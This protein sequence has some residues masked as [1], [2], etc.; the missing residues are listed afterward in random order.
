MSLYD[1]LSKISDQIQRQ[2]KKME[3]N[4]DATKLVSVQPFIRALG[5]D[6]HNLGEVFPEFKAD[7]KISGGERVDY[8]IL[9]EDKPII[10]IEAKAVNI[11]LNESNWKQLYNYFNAKEVRLG[12]L[13]NGIMYRFYTDMEKSNIM[14]K[15]PFLEIDL[16]NLDKRKVDVLEG[17]TKA[18]FDPIKSIRYMKIRAKVERILSYPDE[19]LVKHVIYNIHDG[20]KWK[21]V[22]EEYRPLVKRAIDDYVEHEAARRVVQ[23]GPD[24]E[25]KKPD[26]ST[27]DSILPKPQTWLD[28]SVKIPVYAS[29]NDH[30]FDATLRLRGK[31]ANVGSI[32]LWEGKW[33]NPRVAAQEARKT[34]DPNS[35]WY[36]NGMTFWSFQDPAD[37]KIRPI[38][39]LTHGWHDDWDL[40][41][42]VITNARR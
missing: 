38:L 5:Y 37:E 14:D 21:H 4:E 34:V 16:M 15:E 31:I 1:E 24:P 17:F 41:L 19:W 3:H 30:D 42:R 39:D 12:I 13:T 36:V 32:V 11:L 18:R 9:S 8:A 27:T 28:G 23:P 26:P 35:H 20:A 22:I 29:W 33:L 10:F 6:P 40:I 7:A 25:P 2:R